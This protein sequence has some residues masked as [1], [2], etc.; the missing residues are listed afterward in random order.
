MGTLDGEDLLGKRG[1]E[2]GR[3]KSGPKK[4]DGDGVKK[5]GNGL[6]C[7]GGKKFSRQGVPLD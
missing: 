4:L 7:L 1:V 5:K 2:V 6:L 3:L